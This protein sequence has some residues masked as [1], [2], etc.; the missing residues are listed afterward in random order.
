MNYI[1]LKK[2]LQKSIEAVNNLSVTNKKINKTNVQKALTQYLIFFE[3][4]EQKRNNGK[5]KIKDIEK[6]CKIILKYLKTLEDKI[7]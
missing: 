7:K 6:E 4:F 2:R 1:K 3:E 5:I